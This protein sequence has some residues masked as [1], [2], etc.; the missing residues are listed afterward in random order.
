LLLL[1][2][3]S[4]VADGA[5]CSWME[6]W[7]NTAGGWYCLKEVKAE[8]KQHEAAEQQVSGLQLVGMPD[9]EGRQP[10]GRPRFRSH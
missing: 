1:L 7:A 4:S 5:C 9:G 3:H 8:R 2:L 6:L 10:L